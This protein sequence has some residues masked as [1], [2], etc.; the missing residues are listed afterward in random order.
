MFK[1]EKTLKTGKHC[2]ARY[3]DDYAAIFYLTAFFGGGGVHPPPPFFS[4][5]VFNDTSLRFRIWTSKGKKKVNGQRY[6]CS[7]LQYPVS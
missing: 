6:V 3:L 2:K 7:E 4:F 5:L 1:Y